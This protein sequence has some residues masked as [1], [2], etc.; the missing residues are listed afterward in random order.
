MEVSYERIGILDVIVFGYWQV[1]CSCVGISMDIDVII[2]VIEMDKE[3]EN[4]W[5]VYFGGKLFIDKILYNI[6]CEWW[7]EMLVEVL[8]N[9]DVCCWRVM[10]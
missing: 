6:C 4:D 10:D 3:V 1:I 5:G 2:V 9:M 7:C 8:C